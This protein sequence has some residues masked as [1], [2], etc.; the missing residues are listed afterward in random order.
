MVVNG[1]ALLQAAP[2]KKMLT[3]K[4][5]GSDGVS[6]GLA[7]VGYDIRLKQTIEFRPSAWEKKL[8]KTVEEVVT[9]FFPV[10]GPM[11][12]VDRDDPIPG[13][14]TIASAIEE[15]D[16]PDN[17]VGIVHDKS[18][19]ARRGLSVFNTVIEPGFRGG[20]TLELVYHGYNKLVLPAGTGIAQVIFH[21]LLEP[22]VYSGVYQNQSSD[23]VKSV[24]EWNQ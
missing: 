16:M 18:T 20:L 13:N 7:E 14:F 10:L 21:E 5:R 15:F 8:G 2:I 1:K 6:Y 4:H 24:T 23:P 11:V 3:E 17:L 19:W 12:T 9:R 22:A